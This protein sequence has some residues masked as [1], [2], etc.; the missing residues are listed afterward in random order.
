MARPAVTTKPGARYSSNPPE[1]SL[2]KVPFAFVGGY[3]QKAQTTGTTTFQRQRK[4]N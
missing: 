4:E 1:M 2:R 3:R